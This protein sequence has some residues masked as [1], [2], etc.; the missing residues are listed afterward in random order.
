METILVY[1][2][3]A[4][5]GGALS[6]LLDYYNKA[7]D[8][9]KNRYI[10]VISKANIV[11]TDRIKV[12]TLPWVKKSWIHRLYCDLYYLGKITRSEQVTRILSLQ[13]IA[14]K[15]KKEI[16]QEVYVHNAIP[17]T[18]HRFLLKD[19]PY[20]WVYQN[21]IGD[22]TKKSL[23]KCDQ[24]IV[25]TEWMKRAIANQCKIDENRIVIEHIKARGKTENRDIVKNNVFFYPASSQKFKNH[26]VVIEACKLIPSNVDYK[27]IFTISE[28]ENKYTQKLSLECNKFNLP[29]EFVGFLDRKT[30]DSYYRHSVL[31]FPSYLETVGLPLVEAQQF[32]CPIIAAACEYA[33]D[34]IGNYRNSTFFE[35]DDCKELS[36][37]MMHMVNNK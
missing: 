28:D 29:V 35:P 20:L 30:V 37:I 25:Q 34:A 11:S 17:F 23:K 27:V 8:D 14:V 21:I 13:N 18:D 22:I 6:V 32:G 24:I 5:S 31:L 1:D 7:K 33:R 10:F 19:D 12:V 2:V 9:Y 3:A 15:C 26:A 16:Y 36:E 4:E